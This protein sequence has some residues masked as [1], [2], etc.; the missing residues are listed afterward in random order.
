VR[1]VGPTLGFRVDWNGVSVAYIPD[2]GPGCNPDDPDDYVPHEV[3]E[4]CDGADLL[5]HDAQH[6]T[7]EYE[8][9]RHWGHCT[10]EYAV[11]VARESGAHRLALFH[12][13]PVHGDA[14]LDRIGLAAG[15]HSAEVGGPEILTAYEGLELFL[16]PPQAPPR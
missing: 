5:I 8:P 6:T 13:D 14:Q 15:D 11:H 7:H 2:H 9:K 4:L 1:H 16:L 10:V 3:L 12:H